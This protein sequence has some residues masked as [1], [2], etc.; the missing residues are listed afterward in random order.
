MLLKY[1]VLDEFGEPLRKFYTKQTAQWFLD[2]RPNCTL[3]QIAVEKRV[4]FDD[5]IKQYGEAPF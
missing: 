2:A 3:K 4:T 5:M 1:L